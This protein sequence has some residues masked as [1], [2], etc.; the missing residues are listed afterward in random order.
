MK[1]MSTL[2]QKLLER[3][4]ALDLP[5]M[6]SEH[7]S[8]TSNGKS[9]SLSEISNIKKTEEDKKKK[10]ETVASEKGDKKEIDKREE[11][12][13]EKG[14][15]KKRKTPEESQHVSEKAVT[16]KPEPV[17]VPSR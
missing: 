3:D 9:V 15:D 7:S 5:E 1:R 11:T 14:S 17:R 2:R 13:K 6:I 4:S 10:E 12:E 16:P 8:S